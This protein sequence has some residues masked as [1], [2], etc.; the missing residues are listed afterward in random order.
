M[1]LNRSKQAT[2]SRRHGFT[3]IELLVVIAIISLLVSLLL[4]AVQQARESARQTQCKNNLK[5]MAL[6][7]HTFHDTYHA[8]PPARLIQS[9]IRLPEGA[10]GGW[11]T[12]LDEPSWLIRLLPFIEKQGL[13]RQWKVEKAYA[14]HPEELRNI[15]VVTF[16]CPDRHRMD[17]AFVP[18][19]KITITFPCGCGGG[20]QLI[21]G[22]AVAD[23]VCNHGDSSPGAVGAP[24]D[25]YW[26][27]NATGVIN[28]SRPVL[29]GRKVTKDWFD[30]VSMSD[31]L[32]GNSNTL[33]LGEPHV[34]R[35]ELGNTPYNGPAYMGRN[36]TN[37]ARIGGPGV[38]IAHNDMD[39][40]AGQFSFGSPHPGIVQ[41]A[42]ADGSVRNIATN[43][44]TRVLGHLANRQDG[45]TISADDF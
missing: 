39:Q 26:G 27:G 2:G 15:P 36:I 45:A 30:K 28:S 6:G 4:P 41:F 31:I 25:F 37:F 9:G 24:T 43:I 38:P 33:L 34:P 18:D 17:S 16:L 42:M 11:A 19:Q 29:D 1:R 20:T 40:R 35:G 44:S 7:L 13:A 14:T 32:D 5:Q 23:Y 3:L 21:P 10:T 22:G 8:F 12:G